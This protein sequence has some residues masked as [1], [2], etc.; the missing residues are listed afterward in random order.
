MTTKRVTR[1]G[2]VWDKRIFW[3]GI[4]LILIPL[5]YIFYINDFDFKYHPY[6]VCDMDVCK[7]PLYNA[8][9][10]TPLN[11][12]YDY[13]WPDTEFLTR[14]VYGKKQNNYFN[15]FV[16]LSISMIITAIG[17]NHLAYNLGKPFDIGMEQFD[18][19]LKHFKN[20]G[21]KFEDN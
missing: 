14:G 15:Q 3:V 5:F 2:Y 6:F 20:L 11:I 17:V 19:Y 8:D 10:N 21:D 1:S 12:G 16:I 9:V 18:K 4:G 7:N 13:D